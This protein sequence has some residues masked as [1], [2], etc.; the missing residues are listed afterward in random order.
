VGK[1]EGLSVSQNYIPSL[2]GLRGLSI[3]IVIL[4]HI[5]LHKFVPGVFGVT[6]F[7][8]IS[9]FII[10]SQLIEE[11]SAT[12]KIDFYKFYMRRIMRLA[13]AL[14]LYVLA[15]TALLFFSRDYFSGRE[16]LS[17]IFYLA[18]YYDI[19]IGYQSHIENTP[20]PF[21]IIW[22]LAVEEHFYILFPFILYLFKSNGR[23][24]FLFLIFVIF[25]GLIW[26]WILYA[27]CHSS[28]P[29]LACGVSLQARFDHSTDTRF[30]T[31][32]VGCLCALLLR[33]S[34][35]RFLTIACHPM[36]SGLALAGLA[37]SFLCRDEQFRSVYRYLIQALAVTVIFL[38]VEFGNWG[39]LRAFLSDRRVVWFGQLSY[40]LYLMHFAALS[41]AGLATKGQIYT[42]FWFA[43][44]LPATFGLAMASYYGVE[45]PMLS[46][47]KHFGSRASR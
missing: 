16:V 14:L 6:V 29:A 38:N 13:P 30:E 20:H 23:R 27:D 9:G 1:I 35:D 21:V 37:C 34:R 19:F 42:L 43:I 11:I 36:I 39:R 32:V 47:R 41:V 17:A 46:W 31:I 26:R 10:T 15:M 5:G 8:V 4:S 2:D 12:Q 7:F 45:R 3:I 24:L 40:S 44:F 28:A 18:N 25:L 22:S 33:L